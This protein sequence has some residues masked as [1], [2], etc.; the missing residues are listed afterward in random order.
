M[1][2]FNIH[3][4]ADRD[5]IYATRAVLTQAIRS[6]I[7]IRS[8]ERPM[9]DASEVKFSCSSTPFVPSLSDLL[10]DVKGQD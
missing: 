6:S 3:L 7:G 9:E 5:T 1:S 4:N 10:L 2:E 8:Q